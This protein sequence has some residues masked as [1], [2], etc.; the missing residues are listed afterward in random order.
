M[1]TPL[2]VG[3]HLII[4]IASESNES[5]LALPGIYTKVSYENDVKPLQQGHRSYNP[6]PKRPEKKTQVCPL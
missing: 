1:G 3:G 4:A 5:N 2:L 6:N